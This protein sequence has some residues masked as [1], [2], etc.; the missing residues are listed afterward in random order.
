MGAKH[1]QHRYTGIVE[2]GIASIYSIRLPTGQ[3]L[4]K[5]VSDDFYALLR[6]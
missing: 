4:A 1:K 6:G 3:I 5:L 2:F